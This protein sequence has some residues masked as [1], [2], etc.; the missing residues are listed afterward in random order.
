VNSIFFLIGADGMLPGHEKIAS[1][2]NEFWRRLAAWQKSFPLFASSDILFCQ[3]QAIREACCSN[4]ERPVIYSY[5]KV[6]L[7]MGSLFGPLFYVKQVRL[8]HD[9]QAIIRVVQQP[10]DLQWRMKHPQQSLQIDRMEARYLRQLIW[11]LDH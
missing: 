4:L 6:V 1:S 2:G 9:R 7:A 8:E 3:Q 10:L 5:L 11:E